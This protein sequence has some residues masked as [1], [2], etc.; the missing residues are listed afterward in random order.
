MNEQTHDSQA[1][2]LQSVQST[3][4][5]GVG[6][7]ATATN[8]TPTTTAPNAAPIN[9]GRS[10]GNTSQGVQ[11]TI[12]PQNV[13]GL[14]L[15]TPVPATEAGSSASPTTADPS[16]ASSGNVPNP[17]GIPDPIKAGAEHLSGISLDNVRVHYN[18]SKPSLYNALGIA[19]DDEVHLAAGQEHLLPHELYHIIQQAEGKVEQ[20]N[21]INKLPINDDPALEQEAIAQGKKI[22]A[23][24]KQ[25]LLRMPQST[26]K[27]AN[28]STKGIAQEQLIN[29][30]TP[31]DV[32]L[33]KEA[34]GGN[35]V[36][37]KELLSR[38]NNRKDPDLV[39]DPSAINDVQAV[40]EYIDNMVQLAARTIAKNPTLAGIQ[41]S[42]GK[43]YLDLWRKT[44]A[45]S[46]AAPA[47][48]NGFLPTRLGYAVETMAIHLLQGKRI[49]NYSIS[50]QVTSGA[51]R[52][53]I[54]VSQNG[55]VV[56][57]LDITAAN[58]VGHIYMKQ[59][60]QWDNINKVHVGEI[61]YPSLANPFKLASFQ[62]WQAQFGALSEAEQAEL[63]K[64]QAAAAADQSIVNET[65][66]WVKTEFETLI[67]NAA[68][69][70]VKIRPFALA[71][72]PKKK[73]TVSDPLK[74]PKTI[75]KAAQRDARV[76]TRIKKGD[77][78]AAFAF[79]ILKHYKMNIDAIHD[80]LGS[81]VPCVSKKDF[82]NYLKTS[83]L[84]QRL[85]ALYPDAPNLAYIFNPLAKYA[86]YYGDILQ[87]DGGGAP[88]NL[89]RVLLRL[90]KARKGITTSID[91]A[92]DA[93]DGEDEGEELVVPAIPMPPV[94]DENAVDVDK[95]IEDE[96]EDEEM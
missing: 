33:G 9:Q 49:G 42:Y 14:Q 95:D 11:N 43:G 87:L 53:D 3:E 12:P 69:S 67:Q 86:G 8:T 36:S 34:Q 37:K 30:K 96:D 45:E 62:A 70:V 41:P 20:T 27:D 35:D 5:G 47:T 54:V 46:L 72:T 26:P 90:G 66:A 83:E 29:Y 28:L 38:D 39:A 24:S 18:S 75:D 16:N 40:A 13:G 81:G 77:K 92:E 21:T 31:Q 57:W 22:E 89:S 17:T 10:I 64:A 32:K 71:K 44:Y 58:S 7:L 73:T 1:E 25:D 94:L 78:K 50:T 63:V 23:L 56:A 80:R 51:T 93:E 59:G 61:L 85:A 65:A 74:L 60:G 15:G 4:R 48:E 84:Y 76:A 2:S 52:P 91:V 55:S 19:I 68:P 6:A 88:A 79:H 82:A